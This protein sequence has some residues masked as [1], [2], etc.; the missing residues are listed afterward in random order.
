MVLIEGEVDRSCTGKLLKQK[1]QLS[2]M[3]RRMRN[4][5]RTMKVADAS[6]GVGR[7]VKSAADGACQT[8][9][10]CVV[11]IPRLID[12]NILLKRVLYVRAIARSIAIIRAR[13]MENWESCT[14]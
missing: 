13:K 6:S 5:I 2:E 4:M 10:A 8:V 7:E 9:Q 1:H 3:T 11:I 12:V 14:L